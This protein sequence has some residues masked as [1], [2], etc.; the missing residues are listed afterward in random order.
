MDVV[1][2]QLQVNVLLGEANKQM[3]IS[4]N[5][6]LASCQP[7]VDKIIRSYAESSIKSAMAENGQVRIK[8]A[9]TVHIYYT[10]QN[11]HHELQH[12][13]TTIP[14]EDVLLL[15]GVTKDALLK[16]SSEVLELKVTLDSQGEQIIVQVTLNNNVRAVRTEKLDVVTEVPDSLN[17]QKVLLKVDA[18]IGSGEK[19]KN[20]QTRVKLPADKPDIEQVLNAVGEFRSKNSKVIARKVVVEGE[21]GVNVTYLAGDP[22]CTVRFIIP[23]FEFVDVPAAAEDMRAEV[24]GNVLEIKA[25]KL[26]KR[27]LRLEAKL[28]LSVQVFKEKQIMVVTGLTGALYSTTE[29]LAEKV[30]GETTSQATAQK[31]CKLDHNLKIMHIHQEK[32]VIKSSKI[33][34]G[35]VEIS[36]EVM[37]GVMYLPEGSDEI[38]HLGLMAPFSLSIE[39]AGAEPGQNLYTMPKVEYADVQVIDRC[40]LRAKAVV[41]IWAK[42][43]ETIAQTVVTAVE[44]V[45]A[46]LPPPITTPPTTCEYQIKP[47]DTFYKLALQIGVPVEEIIKLNPTKNPQNLIP[48]DTIILPVC[49]SGPPLG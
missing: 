22:E 26:N 30:V 21:I 8:G 9:V 32:A 40:I 38:H 17:P 19:E 34:P 47:G 13:D 37:L 42:V 35:K 20:L 4:K 11:R 44:A 25:V 7:P 31:D 45:E 18:V 15:P 49:P 16:T 41:Q 39:L 14:F 46:T 33:T 36:G 24:A 29:L 27:E 6:S 5:I 10:P 48:G 2:E 43:T 23:V 3:Q 28:N 1:K 12:F